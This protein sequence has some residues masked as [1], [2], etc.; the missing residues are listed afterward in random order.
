MKFIPKDKDKRN[1]LI[2]TVVIICALLG[3]F[4]FFVIRAQYASIAAVV[5][6][7]NDQ[8]GKLDKIKKAVKM[9]VATEAELGDLSDK[10]QQAEQNMASDDVYA[11]SYDFIRHFKTGYAVNIPTVDQP[12]VSDVDLL[13]DFP[14]RQVKIS[15]NGS[16]YYHDFGKFV[17]DLEN[18]YPYMRVVN[19]TLE[20]SANPVVD[21]EKLNFRA[22]IIALVKPRS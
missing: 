1:K 22:D 15:L 12:A 17:A 6:K 20:S 18:K 14:Y 11:W 10:L 7:T 21:G 3:L 16:G 5:Q 19:V 9:S 2:L 4:F 8:R 13:A